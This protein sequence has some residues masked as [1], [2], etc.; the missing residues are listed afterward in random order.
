ML[1][2]LCQLLTWQKVL[3]KRTATDMLVGK[4][5]GDLVLSGLTG[6]ELASCSVDLCIT[7]A[8]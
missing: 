4:E 3:D 7:G 5:D 2:L 8:S 1:P 6:S